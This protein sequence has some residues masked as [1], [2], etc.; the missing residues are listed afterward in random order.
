M[1]IFNIFVRPEIEG[2]IAMNFIETSILGGRIA[3]FLPPQNLSVPPI[4]PSCTPSV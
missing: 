1:N 2:Q 4:R 3:Y